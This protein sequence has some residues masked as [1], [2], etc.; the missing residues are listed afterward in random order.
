MIA[1]QMPLRSGMRTSFERLA[2]YITNDQGKAHRV[3]AVRVSNCETD[4]LKLDSVIHEI[5]ATQGQNTRARGDKTFH[6]MIGFPVG[7]T[8]SEEVL[9]SIEESLCTG[10]GY[11]E[12]QRISAVHNDTDHL[13][14][15]IAIN[16]IH[17]AKLTMHEPYQSYRRLGEICAD[18][19]DEHGLQRVNHQSVRSLSE[20]L[21]GDMERHSGIESLVGWI[22]HNCL[23]DLHSADNW[24]QFHRVMEENGLVI[25]PRGN[26]LVIQSTD[27]TT[28]K[29]STVS[30]DLSKAKLEARLGPFE[31]GKGIKGKAKRSYSKRPVRFR[32]NTTE[33]YARYQEEQEKLVSHRRDAWTGVKAKRMREIDA[34]RRS[35]RLRRAVI[36]LMGDSGQN[37]RLLYMQASRSLKAEINAINRRH[38]QERQSA[39]GLYRKKAWVDWLQKQANAGDKKALAA[40]RSRVESKGLSSLNGG[41]LQGAR[42]VQVNRAIGVGDVTKQGTEVLRTKAGTVLRTDGEKLSVPD[43]AN[44]A[45]VAEAL[46]ITVAR[47]GSEISVAGA[48]SFKARAVHAAVSI[49]RDTAITFKDSAL[50]RLKQTALNREQTTHEQRKRTSL[51]RGRADRGSISDA[52]TAGRRTAGGRGSGSGAGPGAGPGAATDRGFRHRKSNVGGIGVAPP[53]FAKNRLRGMSS[54]GLVQ[55]ADGGE[56]LLPSDVPSELEHERTESNNKL[57]RSVSRGVAISADQAAEKYISEREGKRLNGFDIPK[58]ARYNEHGGSFKFGGIRNVDGHAL[59]LLRSSSIVSS[60]SE[61]LVLPIEPSTAKRLGRVRIGEGVVITPSGSLEK[62]KSRRR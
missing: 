39:A 52:R 59:A 58:H 18:L 20:G 44:S 17:P 11:G 31:P 3:G 10:L 6:L 23:E 36:K 4:N 9:K 53:P 24:R 12:H 56:V 28:A 37:K 19:E 41:T 14:I 61:V 60:M 57:R 51:E 5:V 8:P 34:A 29:A 7:E 45:D 35:N 40:L 15:H 2:K 42:V 33:L 50:E 22:K 46:R 38:R 25:F 30:R 48:P 32:V 26:G 55:F 13:H 16:K 21:A 27:G 62:A 49:N 1:R 47:Y 43:G 54:L